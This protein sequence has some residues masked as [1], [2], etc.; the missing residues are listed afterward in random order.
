MISE[1]IFTTFKHAV[2]RV[3]KGEHVSLEKMMFEIL[4]QGLKKAFFPWKRFFRLLFAQFHERV[5]MLKAKV[6]LTEMIWRR[7]VLHCNFFRVQVWWKISFWKLCRV[8][9]VFFFKFLYEHSYI[10]LGIFI[11][12]F[13]KKFPLLMNSKLTLSR[14]K[15]RRHVSDWKS[16]KEFQAKI[17]MFC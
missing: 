7:K 15:I 9:K 6:C 5:F 10:S 14:L 16:T 3:N 8:V 1:W 11:F 4:R 13:H 17:F 2:I 12:H